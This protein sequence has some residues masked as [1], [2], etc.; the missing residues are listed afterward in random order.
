MKKRKP[1]TKL[2]VALEALVKNGTTQAELAKRLSVSKGTVSL[3]ISGQRAPGKEYL[4]D[5]HK[6]TGVSTDDMLTVIGR[7]RRSVAEL[8]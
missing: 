5:L 7:R 6:L 2:S 3:W 1:K 8:V 4:A